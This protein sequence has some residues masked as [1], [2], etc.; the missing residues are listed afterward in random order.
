ML[1]QEHRGPQGLMGRAVFAIPILSGRQKFILFGGVG[2]LLGELGVHG[3]GTQ[4]VKPWKKAGSGPYGPLTSD[5]QSK[6]LKTHFEHPLRNARCREGSCEELLRHTF[7]VCRNCSCV[8]AKV[9]L[10]NFNNIE[11]RNEGL[12]LSES[13]VTSSLMIKQG[14]PAG[15]T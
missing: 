13:K 3:T 5:V 6:A 4:L 12:I 2:L 15:G 11:P 1:G 9:K 8:L 7:D 14:Q 10:C